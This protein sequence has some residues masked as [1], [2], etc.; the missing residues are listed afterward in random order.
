MQ[1][2]NSTTQSSDETGILHSNDSSKVTS[3]SVKVPTFSPWSLFCFL[4][5]MPDGY[6]PDLVKAQVQN[7]LGIFACDDHLAISIRPLDLG[8]DANLKIM[9]PATKQ[10]K[11]GSWGS[12]LNT[13]SFLAA[14]DLVLGDG[15]FRSQ[16][17]TVKVD[18]DC[19][20]FPTRLV[21]HLKKIFPGGKGTDSPLYIRNCPKS[22]GLM[23]A[24]EIFSQGAIDTYGR[25]KDLC[26]NCAA[27]D[28]GEDG[29]IQ[30]C[31][32]ALNI[33]FKEDFYLMTDGYCQTG[34]CKDQYWSVGFHPY[35]DV[36]SWFKCHQEATHR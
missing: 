21:W 1:S 30:A 35:K 33:S 36:N 32:T 15:S 10:G 22:F 13:G 26:R 31:M 29:F 12:W 4:V 28:S 17:W 2:L 24:L 23:G 3:P 27:P 8:K 20:F 9:A 25:K 6:E 7:K 11:K 5:L 14:W 34:V 19:V 18:P 16:A